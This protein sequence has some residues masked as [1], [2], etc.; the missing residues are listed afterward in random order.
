MGQLEKKDG[1]FRANYGNSAAFFPARFALC[2]VEACPKRASP[3]RKQIF[4][5]KRCAL[6]RFTDK[7][8]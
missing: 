1:S 7:P 2:F 8:S 3:A 4:F 5:A 6:K